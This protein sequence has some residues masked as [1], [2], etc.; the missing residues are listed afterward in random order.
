MI[1][2]YRS[3]KNSLHERI[4]LVF[5]GLL[6]LFVALFLVTFGWW[7][8]HA[9]KRALI[10]NGDIQARAIADA[11]AIALYTENTWLLN[12]R[13]ESLAA[14]SNN[15]VLVYKKDGT[16]W[17]SY[18]E[19][20]LVKDFQKSKDDVMALLMQTV[21]GPGPLVQE[22]NG[23]I[24]FFVP[25]FV[26]ELGEF[27][28]LEE[29]SFKNIGLLQLV[30]PDDTPLQ[31]KKLLTVAGAI[32]FILI[33]ISLLVIYK[34]ASMLSAPLVNLT[35]QVVL[36]QKERNFLFHTHGT[37]EIQELVYA[38]NALHSSRNQAERD[39]IQIKERLETIMRSMSELVFIVGENYRIIYVN[40]AVEKM[41]GLNAT[42]QICCQYLKLQ[43]TP[44]CEHCPN[45]RILETM[46]GAHWNG[47]L[48]DRLFEF[49]S[50]PITLPDGTIGV[51]HVAKDVTDTK[52]LEEERI[53]AQRLESIGMLAAG[54]AH[55]FNNVLM[56]ILGNI[57]L[58]KM[59]LAP[60]T[61]SYERLEHAE[62]ACDKAKALANQLLA[63]AKGG[64]P[65]KQLTDIGKL[66]RECVEFSSHGKNVRM[67]FDI[68]PD[69]WYA[70]VDEGQMSQVINN[71]VIN[72]IQAMPN[73]GT[74]RVSMKNMSLT[75]TSTLELP[76]GPYVLISVS[77][78]G[79]GI[80]PDL[81]P[82][83]FDPFFTTKPMGSGLGL[84]TSYTIIKRHKGRITV[85]SEMGKGTVF[86]IYLPARPSKGT[87]PDV[88]DV[89]KVSEDLS[90]VP[91]ARVL[92]M[93]DDDM[94][95]ESL[96]EMLKILGFTAHRARDGAEAIQAY[97]DML[98][99]G[100]R[101]Y[102]VILDL[103]IPGGMGGKDALS[104]LSSL[105]S[106]V[107]AVVCSGYADDPVM[108]NYKA[109]G[110]AAAM[111][112]PVSLHELR[113]VFANLSESHE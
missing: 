51:L 21:T 13:M 65:V 45:S 3:I 24:S 58:A 73:G 42:N 48:A 100:E 29:P 41:F 96:S 110:F 25:V 37:R 14:L 17:Q 113:H 28:S 86:H 70:E 88:S 105:D 31:I 27:L 56:A 87:T 79:T 94:V 20:A 97:K 78:T 47:T 92:V 6:L 4:L 46:Q 44:P 60:G 54:I 82:K 8:W 111:S 15:L 85:E 64:A 57:S 89:M 76:A 10:K 11:S 50:M 59:F 67:E 35:Q 26:K 75:D 49:A 61:K 108:T 63:F 9:S 109:Y 32:L 34:F 7:E 71:L 68:P 84:A 74:V 99:N 66:V 90:V 16:L 72:A 5:V 112:K 102:A 81:L 93:D 103:T 22:K 18:G 106:N 91:N 19:Q 104:V 36:A 62:K 107:R 77:D 1:Y 83:I 95:F 12:T 23:Y 69:T 39:V 53:K 101:Y 43:E 33:L 40:S 80:A 52:R 38:F 55:D 98:V 2:F 30:I